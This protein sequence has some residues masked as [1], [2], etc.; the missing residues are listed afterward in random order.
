MK[1]HK[2]SVEFYC[3]KL[4]N[5]MAE[6]KKK[7]KNAERSEGGMRRFRPA[8][9]SGGIQSSM[10]LTLTAS[11][12]GSWNHSQ[13]QQFARR[14]QNL[15]EVITLKITVYNRGSIQIKISQRKRHIG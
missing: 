3:M 12:G 11:S 7:I 1:V 15:L 13:V 14:I 4:S 9:Q 5:G 6:L 10:R 2:G 8:I